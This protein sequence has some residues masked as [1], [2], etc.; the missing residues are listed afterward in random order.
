M[1]KEN[2]VV[3][4]QSAGNDLIHAGAGFVDTVNTKFGERPVIHLRPNGAARTEKGQHILVFAGKEMQHLPEDIIVHGDV[5]SKNP[6][7]V[8][9]AGDAP[10]GSGWLKQGKKE[11][12]S[13]VLNKSVDSDRLTVFPRAPSDAAE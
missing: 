2:M 7:Y 12:L 8:V 5:A 1:S 11:F 10:V 9:Y 6:Q 13:L 3:M 4:R